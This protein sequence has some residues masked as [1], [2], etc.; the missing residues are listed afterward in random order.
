[1]KSALRYTI[2]VAIVLVL[3]L[4]ASLVLAGI[5]GQFLNVLYIAL[6]VLAV[7][8]LLSTAL[9]I[10]A[11]IKLIQTII[12]VHDE[13]QPLLASMQETVGMAKETAVVVKETAQYAGK[14]AGTLA[15]ATRLTKDYAIT[16]PVRAAALILAGRQ[17]MKIFF[18]SG[19]VRSRAEE[20]RLRQEELL[21]RESAGGE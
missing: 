2:I 9:L 7:F 15:S 21:R 16:P 11:V 4:V 13:V 1:M 14:A 20:R 3:L 17:M 6:I 12:L 18:G 8:S 19:H 5:F 10:Y